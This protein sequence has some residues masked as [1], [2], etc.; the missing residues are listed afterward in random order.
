MHLEIGIAEADITPPEGI[1]GRL[2]LDHTLSIKHPIFARTLVLKTEKGIFVQITCELVGHTIGTMNRIY[3]KLENELGLDR[4]KVILTCTHTHSSPWIW[5]LQ[6]KEAERFGI[7]L[8]NWHW[9][10]KVIDGCVKS[11]RLALKNIQPSILKIGSAVVK[12]VAS[13]RV[14]VGPRWSICEDDSLR[15]KPI[16]HIDPEVRV[17]SVYDIEDELRA[18]FVNYACHPSAYG[19][20]K[21]KFVSPDFPYYASEFVSQHF[22]KHIPMSYWQGCAGDINVG[23]FNAH[24]SEEEVQGF[25]KRLAKGILKSLDNSKEIKVNADDIIFTTKDLELPVGEWVEPVEEART[26]FDNISR[27]VKNY[28]EKKE[29]V[30]HNIVGQWRMA[31][32]RLDVCLLSNSDKMKVRLYLWKLGNLSLVFVPGEWFV[33]YGQT[34][35]KI[36]PEI[37]VWITTLTNMDLLY[38]PDKE[39]MLY[40]ERYGVNPRMRTISDESVDIMVRAVQ[41]MIKQYG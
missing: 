17:L 11:V 33:R 16:G 5:D 26:K 18:L 19:G 30:P 24:G 4:N 35:A 29:P 22:G 25:G 39:S 8:L 21:T 3:S 23:K 7:K 32:K 10:D 14:E 13:N 27:Q 31:I 40:R 41:S 38:I 2:G 6:S 1:T 9:L 34:L 37:D 28:L 12:D 36:N 15:A 20:G